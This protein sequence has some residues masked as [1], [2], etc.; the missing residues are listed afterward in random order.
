MAT[1]SL[2]LYHGLVFAWY[3]FLSYSLFTIDPK[4]QP[5]GVFL[6]GGQWKYLTVLN[7]VLQTLFYAVSVLADLLLPVRGNKL[8]RC[9]IYCRDLLFSV[10][11]FPA[12]S[13]VFLSF[14][15]LYSYDRQLVYPEGLDKVIPLW[16][17][18]AMH[19]AV[20]PLAVLEIAASPHRY[21]PKRKG[22]TL[23]GICSIVYISWIIWIY[24]AD[25]KWVYPFL[26][27]LNPF[28]FII[29]LLSS[30]ILAASVYIAG[31][32]LNYLMWGSPICPVSNKTPSDGTVVTMGKNSMTDHQGML[33]HW[34]PL[35]KG[36]PVRI[37]TDNTKAVVYVNH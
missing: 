19:T 5:T 11:A 28:G 21:P 24:I 34:S 14:W 7:V 16:L 26:G 15:A 20:F 37:Q 3:F 17:N 6:Y 10:L 13:F 25:G 36:R 33:V 2:L 31:E 23:L 27:L 4:E 22:L 18:H 8:V 29:F 30:N 35:L 12:A 1:A 9:I 32:M